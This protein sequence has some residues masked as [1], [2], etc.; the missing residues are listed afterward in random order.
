MHERA[1][2]Q[3]RP[4]KAYLCA[5]RCESVQKGCC[6][7]AVIKRTSFVSGRLRKD[8]TD[9]SLLGKS[10]PFPL[11]AR[12][13]CSLHMQPHTATHTRVPPRTSKRMSMSAGKPCWLLRCCPP[14]AAS[15]AASSCL[16][17]VLLEGLGSVRL[18]GLRG[19]DTS[20]S[21]SLRDSKRAWLRGAAACAVH[22]CMVYGAQQPVQSMRA[23]FMGRSSLCGPCVHGLWGAAACAVHACM[24]YGAQQPVRSMR[25]WCTGRSSLCGPSHGACK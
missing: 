25:A 24:V 8:C 17:I 13:T 23:W 22:A 15:N 4:C 1:A 19:G 12:T 21:S 14:Q 9:K 3:V 10:L 11:E 6:A 20:P 5:H 16:L 2:A 18:R 7:A